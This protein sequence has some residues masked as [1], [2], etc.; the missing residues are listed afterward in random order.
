MGFNPG[1]GMTPN[2][3]SETEAR[4]AERAERADRPYGREISSGS[5][6]ATGWIIGLAAVALIV[7]ALLGWL[8]VISVP[9]FNA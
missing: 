9:G 7:Y 2:D 6:R 5:R 1:T 8:G 3:W 4:R